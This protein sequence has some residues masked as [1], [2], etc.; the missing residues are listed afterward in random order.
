VADVKLSQVRAEELDKR[1]T[2]LETRDMEKNFKDLVYVSL[3][4]VR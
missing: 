4:E 2:W 1:A 3:Q